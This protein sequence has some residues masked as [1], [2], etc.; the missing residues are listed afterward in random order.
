M[1]DNLN[2]DNL[3]ILL[4]TKSNILNQP[5]IF[6]KNQ[7]DIGKDIEKDIEIAYLLRK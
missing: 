4:S 5:I 1:R 6:E 2:T 3:F 7:K